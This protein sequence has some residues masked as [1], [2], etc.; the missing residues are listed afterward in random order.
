V[1]HEVLVVLT[2]SGREESHHY[3]AYCV[4][5][6]GKVV[7]S[8]GDIETPVYLRSAAKPFQALAAVESG[9]ADRF[10][11]T[12]EELALVVGSHSGSPHHAETAHT[13]L[14]KA[15]ECPTL[16]RCG[17]HRPLSREV[18]EGYVRAHYIPGRLEDNC[19]GK[20]AGMIAAAKAWGEETKSY[21][22][23]GHRVQRHNLHNMALFS[24]VPA[25]DIPIGVDGCAVPSFAV[26]MRSAAAAIARYATPRDLPD[27]NAEAVGRVTRAVQAHPAMV[28]GEGRFDTR[29][30]AAPGQRLIS[31]EGAE[32]VQLVGVIGERLGIAVK[33][34]DGRRRATEA[35]VGAL[36][37]DLGL[38][39]EHTLTGVYP[40]LVYTREGAP[41]GDYEVRL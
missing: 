25:D 9:A 33:S 8:R 6:D 2:R 34:A 10:G 28:G 21:A 40:R 12:D 18:D 4:W 26:S 7:R 41:V 22:E 37:L 39:P 17:G 16:L 35:V 30:L 13:M 23:P 32:G 29:L 14:K 31:K 24:G 19:S 38:V 5:R 36:L 11:F 3:G 1:G 20:H 15:G 27:A